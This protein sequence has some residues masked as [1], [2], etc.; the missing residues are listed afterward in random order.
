MVDVLNEWQ[1]IVYF[2]VSDK[3]FS[4]RSLSDINNEWQR[5]IQSK[6]N[7][8]NNGNKSSNGSD[9]GEKL[10]TSAARIKKLKGW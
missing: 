6:S 2:I 9:S 4:T 10:G 1:E 8:N 3:W 7:K 5:L